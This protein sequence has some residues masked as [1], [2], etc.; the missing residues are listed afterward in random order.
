MNPTDQV[1]FNFAKIEREYKEQTKGG[2]LGGTVKANFDLKKMQGSNINCNKREAFGCSLPDTTQF[3]PVGR[4]ALRLQK[5]EE[6][7][8]E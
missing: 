2:T 8:A 5:G 7:Y 4:I 1:S 3:K 6:V